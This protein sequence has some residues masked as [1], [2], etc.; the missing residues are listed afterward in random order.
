LA[1]T[2]LASGEGTTHN[3]TITADDGNGNT[4][5]CTV[6][7]TGDD[8]TDPTFTLPPNDTICRNPD[9][10]Y[11]IDPSVTG[12][13]IDEYDNCGTGLDAIYDDD[14][15][16]LLSCDTNGYII[17]TWSLNDNNG[18]ITEKVQIIWVE[19]T[20]SV[21]VTPKQDTICNS[22]AVN[23]I[24]NSIT[25]PT[26]PVK[27]RY[28]T[29]APAG[30]TII[31]ASGGPLD[32][33]AILTNTINNMN[34]SARLVRFIITPYTRCAGSEL[35]KCTGINDTA[36]VWVEPTLTVDATPEHDTLC[37]AE[38][39]D[40][41]LNSISNPTGPVLFRYQTNIPF[42]V[43]V[44][45]TSET[46][47]PNGSVLT[48]ILVNNTDTAKQVL[49]IITPYTRQAGSESEKCAGIADTVEIWIEPVPKVD[50]T[51][52]SDT[53]CTSLRS[54]V[55][56]TTVT[57]SL[58]PVRFIYEAIYSI[59]DV[60]LFYEQ[61]T[62][63]LI[64]GFTITDSIVNH[65]N[66][67]QRVTIVAYP[68]LKSPSG[69]NKCPGIADT[70]F[71]WI[72]P[73]LHVVVDTISTYIGGNNIRCFGQNNGSIYLN[74]T[75]GMTAFAGYDYYDLNYSWSN[76]GA[77]KD[78]KNL[79][80]GVYTV[81]ITDRF[82]CRDDSTF[83]LSQP[84][85]LT[86]YVEQIDTLSCF[87][88]DG[89]IAP[90]TTGGTPGYFYK[91]EEVPYDYMLDPPVYEDTLFY[92]IEGHY[93]LRVTDTNSCVYSTTFDLSQPSA[94][95]VGAIP[96]TFGNYQLKCFGD[97]SG[98]WTSV[99]NSM[100]MIWY[101][102][103]GPNGFDT[104]FTNASRFN[105]Q[106]N[107][108]AGR[109]S[110]FY[111]DAAGCAGTF[112]LDMNQPDPIS[113]DQT[114]LSEY[115]NQYNISCYGSAD[116]SIT[117]DHI[118]GGHENIGYTFNW[119]VLTG[120]GSVDS[121]SRNQ[122]NMAAGIYSVAV[123]DTFNCSVSDTFELL[124]PDEIIIN[125]EVSES[126]GGG[127][128]I[129][130][131][132]QNTGSILIQATGGA[133]T[134]SYQYK[135]Q[136][137]PV[138]N[139]VHN[140]YAGSYIYTVTDDLDCSITDTVVLSQPQKLQ[141][142]SA[143][144]SDFNGF[145]VAC[146][147]IANGTIEVFG[148]GGEG[149]FGY[150]WTANGVPLS[151]DTAFI[152]NLFA[153]EYKLVLHDVNYCLVNWT[154][155][156]DEPSP[157]SIDIETKNVNCTGTVLGNAQA[158]VTG[159]VAPYDYLWNN[160]ETTPEINNLSTGIYILTIRD[161]NN[162]QVNDT[163]IIDQNSTL[164]IA[165]QIME[166]ISCY[167]GSDGI[168]KAFVS[169]GIAPYS[170][171]W[172]NG[173]TNEYLANIQ[174]GTY[175]VTVTDMDGCTNS[176]N[177]EVDDP[178][179]LKVIIVVTEPRCFGSNDGSVEL[180]ATGGTATY[181]YYWNN[182]LVSGNL[183]EDISSGSYSIRVTDIEN[184]Q[185]DTSIVVNQPEILHIDLDERYTVYPFCPD[186]QNGS[187]AVQ[188]SGGTPA[189]EYSWAGY[190]SD[191]DSILNDIKE[192]SYS[193]RVID[194]RGCTAD[195]TFRL[196]AIHNACLGIPTAFT[197]NY[198]YANDTWD[199]SYI[200][201]DGGEAKFHEVY[202]NGVIQIYDRLGNLVYRCTGGCPESWNGEDLKGRQLPV[203]T[204]YYIIELNNGEDQ[205]T[206]KGIV[207]IIR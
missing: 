147:G 34:D 140:L 153:G 200:T 80:A 32:N 37:S 110:L 163:A 49:F 54:G 56:I 27:F 115:N 18:N 66:I 169:N 113:V 104:I 145:E 76:G 164:E 22:Y 11:N 120:N 154:G 50:L 9:C 47:L 99:N 67:P 118:S 73:T 71:I 30:V 172:N 186:W 204:Y 203:D 98:K 112:I 190:P 202:P 189:Y 207:T 51:P 102:W 152:E 159:G 195:S 133:T 201:E 165:I 15:S 13:V 158:T 70:S 31:P 182:N 151:Q 75:G 173:D 171:L 183:V 175:T 16:N 205:S 136:H 135:W 206:I 10:T 1:G 12:D 41:N 20:P 19:P 191:N 157:I 181:K 198:D 35:E 124:Q 4:S 59:P 52:G 43:T 93:V 160:G 129:N 65:T 128:N 2:L 55:Q 162:C 122:T 24:L 178:D 101:H 116:G 132:G 168:I 148:S 36:Y 117:L 141:I 14:F 138:T 155:T 119:D 94:L 143:I 45:P 144:I 106:E 44:T 42:G 134:G 62:F 96:E 87:G 179:Q 17:R 81:T 137:G 156:L 121:S 125:E 21:S 177:I 40:I 105:V 185:S 28:V 39:V 86:T 83:T 103:T 126:T 166:N 97:N 167:L 193:L 79:N 111:T 146:S 23:I 199:I 6:V 142:D 8:D 130:C 74:P 85:K 84:V 114:T 63:D 89:T 64:P 197:P 194:A 109:Y 90:V 72:A 196:T 187:L 53:I 33:N 48:N 61:D 192:D 77:T 127:Y 88:A 78:I 180:D 100:T 3:I 95:Y 5:T 29:E 57:R 46:A 161:N 174:A 60:S 170:Y 38:Q 69:I 91:W 184:C 107:V 139:E 26:R 188:V 58:Q 82:N 7:L 92:V 131:F 108:S 68:Y 176:Q 123:M 149:P 150:N 25:V